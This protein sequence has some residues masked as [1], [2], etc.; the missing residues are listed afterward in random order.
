MAVTN[1]IG[2]FAT[3]KE[4]AKGSV[5]HVTGELKSGFDYNRLIQSVIAADAQITQFNDVLPNMNDIF[6]K[7]VQNTN[8]N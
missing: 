4:N 6:I 7:A 3:I 1:V 2:Q 5:N 8:A